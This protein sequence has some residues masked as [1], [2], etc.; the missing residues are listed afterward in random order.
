MQW[1]MGTFCTPWEQSTNQRPA[2]LVTMATNC[3][4]LGMR[5]VHVDQAVCGMGQLQL[6]G[7]SCGCNVVPL[8][9]THPRNIPCHLFIFDMQL[10]TVDPQTLLLTD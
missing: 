1:R 2:M 3:P 6:V 8:T 7:V 5:C 9:H 4:L 10:L